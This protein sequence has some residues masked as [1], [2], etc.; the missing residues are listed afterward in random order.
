MAIDDI[1]LSTELAKYFA[2]SSRTQ[3]WDAGAAAE[4]EKHATNYRWA[5]HV[6][7]QGAFFVLHKWDSKHS[8]RL[9]GTPWLK[10]YKKEN[11]TTA[12]YQD[13]Q[14]PFNGALASEAVDGAW[15]YYQAVCLIH[16]TRVLGIAEDYSLGGF[17]L[18]N[19]FFPD[20]LRRGVRGYLFS[21]LIEHGLSFIIQG[22]GL[23][24]YAQTLPVLKG[25]WPIQIE[26]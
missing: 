24:N 3:K 10:V 17:V 5:H 11:F 21:Q 15:R 9:T 2:F 16:V 6:I 23:G 14:D 18:E 25:W 4:T 8:C 20:H 22:A 26:P 12:N 1:T 19:S 13:L 7:K